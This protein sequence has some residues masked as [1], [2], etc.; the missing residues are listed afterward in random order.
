MVKLQSWSFQEYGVYPYIGQIKL[1][2]H[3]LNNIIII[4]I[5]INYLKLYNHVQIMYIT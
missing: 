5:F 4:I 3:L 1:H 2:S